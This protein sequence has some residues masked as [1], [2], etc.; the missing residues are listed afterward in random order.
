MHFE[1]KFAATPFH[2]GEQFSAET[3]IVVHVNLH[4][5]KIN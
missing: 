4:K 1:P 2:L 3:S 5:P